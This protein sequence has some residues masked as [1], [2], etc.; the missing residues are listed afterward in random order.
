[1]GFFS[2]TKKVTVTDAVFGPLRYM[3]SKDN[4][5][6]GVSA[7]LFFFSKNVKEQAVVLPSIDRTKMGWKIKKRYGAHDY[8]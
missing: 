4:Y 3:G 1:M 8:R 7:E 5:S 6:D 2:S